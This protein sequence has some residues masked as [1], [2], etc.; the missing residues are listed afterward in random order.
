MDHQNQALIDNVNLICRLGGYFAAAPNSS[1]QLAT[2]VFEQS[3]FYYITGGSCHIRILDQVFSAKEGDWFY[4]PANTEHGYFPDKKLPMQK[5]WM[6]FDLYQTGCIPQIQQLPVKVSVPK[7]MQGTV[8]HYFRVFTEHFFSP[9]LSS[10]LNAKAAGISL[11]A[12]YVQLAYPGGLT[13]EQERSNDLMFLLSYIRKNI[14]LPLSNTDMAGIL[15][16]HPV[17]FCKWFFDHVGLTPQR[18]L[19][20]TRLEVA[21]VLLEK[22]GGTI[23]EIARNAGFYDNAHFSHAFRRFYGMSPS[24]Y[25]IYA[26][27]DTGSVPPKGSR[28]C[29][30]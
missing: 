1:W 4:I 27:R 13:V 7:E 17:Y 12:L 14:A 30:Q 9:D 29:V 26:K 18:Y 28:R 16:L 23:N 19:L 25:R 20:Q 15:H 21:K 5:Y 2:T 3:K 22:D 11:F 10:R 6:H 24:R 8:A